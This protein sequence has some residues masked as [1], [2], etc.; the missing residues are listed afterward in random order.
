MVC[1]EQTLSWSKVFEC[2]YRSRTVTRPAVSGYEDCVRP[3]LKIAC[4]VCCQMVEMTVEEV[5]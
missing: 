4:S 1:G 2:Y 5:G 3:V